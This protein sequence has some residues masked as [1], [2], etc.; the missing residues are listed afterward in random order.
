MDQGSGIA[1]SVLLLHADDLTR[2]LRRLV[3]KG[4][5]AVD[6]PEQITNPCLPEI[7]P[8]L[9][10]SLRRG[11]CGSRGSR[12]LQ[13]AKRSPFEAIRALASAPKTLPLA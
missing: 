5:P 6:G 13:V 12:W 11:T 7:L 1:L 9:R 3:S 2:E 8:A 10:T 4:H